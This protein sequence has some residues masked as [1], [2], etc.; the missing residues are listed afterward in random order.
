MIAKQKLN[1]TIIFPLI[2]GKH[3]ITAAVNF[4][5]DGRVIREGVNLP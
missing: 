1:N 3:Y 2:P 4:L 5:F